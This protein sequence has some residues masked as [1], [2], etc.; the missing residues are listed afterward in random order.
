MTAKAFGWKSGLFSLV[1]LTVCC[2]LPALA[3]PT[4]KINGPNPHYWE[5]SVAYDDQGAIAT[6]SNGVDIT[7]DI[8]VDG[9]YNL[10]TSILNAEYD[11]VYRVVDSTGAWAT[12]S[13]RVIIV[14][15][16][17][18]I[19]ALE[20]DLDNV[21][22][23]VPLRLIPVPFDPD[24]K[25][26]PPLW[27]IWLKQ[28]FGPFD[29]QE[30]EEEHPKPDEFE[31]TLA[32]I[33]N[34]PE[35]AQRMAMVWYF[36]PIG[37]GVVYEIPDWGANP[38]EWRCSDK[39][40]EDPGVKVF[41]AC[42][43]AVPL[44]EVYVFMVEVYIE[45]N[46]VWEEDLWNGK[47]TDLNPNQLKSPGSKRNLAGYRLYYYAPDTSRNIGVAVRDV[48]PRYGGWLTLAGDPNFSVNCGDDSIWPTILQLEKLDRYYDSCEGDASYKISKSG[49][50]NWNV[51][52]TYHLV[53]KAGNH[54]AKRTI[55]VN[56]AMPVITLLDKN[57][58]PVSSP[59]DSAVTLNWCEYIKLDPSAEG[60]VIVDDYGLQR[61]WP[62][63]PDEGF[64]ATDGC[65]D[66]YVISSQTQA[67]G[68]GE[69]SKQLLKL[70]A[71]GIAEA[72]TVYE[73]IWYE[74]KDPRNN[75]ANKERPAIIVYVPPILSF[76]ESGGSSWI[77]SQVY[78]KANKF[79]CG[80]SITLSQGKFD[81][82]G[83]NVLNV[84]AYVTDTGGLDLENPEVG[85]YS[86]TYRSFPDDPARGLALTVQVEVVDNQGPGVI[87]STF[88][89]LQ[90]NEWF[91]PCFDTTTQDAY[92]LTD[93]CSPAT[94]LKLQKYVWRLLGDLATDAVPD[95]VRDKKGRPVD[96]GANDLFKKDPGSYIIVYV[97]TD[98]EG[99]TNLPL[100]SDG[101]PNVFHSNGGVN[102]FASPGVLSK[103]FEESVRIVRT[104]AA[105]RLVPD[106]P[107][108]DEDG[109]YLVSCTEDI[110]TL[111]NNSVINNCFADRV[112]RFVWKFQNDGSIKRERTG[113]PLEYVPE[114]LKGRLGDYVAVLVSYLDRQTQPLLNE[115]VF[116]DI[117]NEKGFLIDPDAPYL[118]RFRIQDTDPPVMTL[119]GDAVV[120]LL[121]GT[122]YVELGCS[123]VDECEGV[124]D[125]IKQEPLPK[126]IDTSKPGSYTI[127]YSAEDKSG[128]TASVTRTVN[129][130]DLTA[131][132]VE[133]VML[134][135]AEIALEC[136]S[137]F[138]DPGVEVRY[139][140]KK[141]N[142]YSRS[143]DYFGV[144]GETTGTVRV[145]YYATTPAGTELLVGQRT[146]IVRDTTAPVIQL[147]G[148]SALKLTQGSVY[149][150]RGARV[151]DSCSGQ[152]DLRVDG[153]VDTGKIGVYTITYG[154]SDASGNTATA[155]RTVTVEKEKANAEGETPE[156]VEGEIEGESPVEGEED[157]DCVG[158]FGRTGCCGARKMPK[159]LLG[160]YLL[161]G[162]SMLALALFRR[163]G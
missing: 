96:Y 10:D 155:V 34:W 40:W 111:L 62:L 72:H 142:V 86:V 154:A 53:Y 162:V 51:P 48:L 159:N 3:K 29:D 56:D 28:Q 126:A 99:N 31:L 23:E 36:F 102:V 149:F 139:K 140:E 150:E 24:K 21:T 75:R 118:M 57:Q 157:D 49:V 84:P 12:A 114:Q 15:T 137:H 88:G 101:L 27:L 143:V 65:D 117:L 125:S 97:V 18:P 64:Y 14:D 147:N 42:D 94:D 106:L 13:R 152:V 11:I 107:M 128:N 44:D 82:L 70:A 77:P 124:L 45:D 130:V 9:L 60:A 105:T 89:T 71:S 116:A 134:G 25:P 8:V 47:Y 145:N 4:I 113:E 6:D 103:R 148:E 91:I 68:S 133:I 104:Q 33:A 85:I 120:T 61:W 127:T 98:A 109:F 95:V 129:I 141:L 74:A 83:C 122:K 78:L 146:V 135:E 43:I 144:I 151:Y 80:R 59:E 52:G 69:I 110:N 131:D 112:D 73:R 58:A 153:Q 46:Y 115:K 90:N 158:C 37:R 1:L 38:M 163:R 138:T 136:G 7:R 79:Q 22:G 54:I 50:V 87:L 39:T 81:L 121:C 63:R 19:F 26:V 108:D 55:Q 16:I 123:A 76:K 161:L 2:S 93:G 20:K 156:V 100:A 35:W 17:P 5:C 41:D 160:E 66:G 30:G 67:Y 92:T 32:D 132:D 119:K